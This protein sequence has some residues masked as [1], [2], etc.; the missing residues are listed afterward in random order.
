M[1]PKKLVLCL[2]CLSNFF[3]KNSNGRLAMLAIAGIYTQDVLFS[4]YGDMLFRK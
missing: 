3:L 1:P 2:I 4:E